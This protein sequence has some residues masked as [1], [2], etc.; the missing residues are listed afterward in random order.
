MCSHSCASQVGRI[1]GEQELRVGDDTPLNEYC[2]Q[3]GTVLHELGHL[4]GFWH[5]QSRP[6]RDNYV[7]I[8]WDNIMK[9]AKDH[10]HKYSH[11]VVDSRGVKYDY[12]S[13]MHYRKRVS[14]C[15]VL[16]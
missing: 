8:V 5:E 12:A 4:L 14:Y 16:L 6:D 15:I 1:G 2:R 7:T 13:I 9:G 3:N 11:G 10:F